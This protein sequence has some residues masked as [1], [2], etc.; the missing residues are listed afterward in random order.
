MSKLSRLIAAAIFLIAGHNVSA[1]SSSTESIAA[2]SLNPGDQVRIVV[3]RQPEFSGDFTISAT[4]MIN[5]PLYREIQVTGIPLSTV[6]ERV[7]A[8]LTR[9][10]TN[11]QFVIQPLVRIVVAGEVRSPNIYSVPPE[12]TIAQALALAG[13]PTDR[14][15]LTKTK[16]V[17]DAQEIPVDLTRADSDVARLHIRSGDEIL[18]TRKGSS[19]RDY[20]APL[21]S[22]IAAA[23]AL[24]NIFL[25]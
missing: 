23:A 21:F 3:W 5:H 15:D 16:I 13:G 25:R 6:E 10:V 4:G 17:R 12:T 9:Y 14:G 11:P 22:G 7:R 8:F 18:V 24:V 19:F 2:S 1:Q 20:V